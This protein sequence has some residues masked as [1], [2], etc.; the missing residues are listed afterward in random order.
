MIEGAVKD[1][2]SIT[3]DWTPIRD[4]I[5]G[6]GFREVKNVLTRN[7]VTTEVFREEWNAGPREI[8]HIIHVTI[9]PGA[10]SAWHCHEIQ[11]DRIFVVHGQMKAALY[12]GRE[13]SATH[14][15]VNVFSLGL[16][17]PGLLVVPPGV[18]HG[19]QNASSEPVGFINF[20]DRAYVYED[21]DEWRLPADTPKIPY[22]F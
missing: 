17:R 8:K 20:F 9:Q 4:M 13:G 10:I 19:L 18:W 6:V 11:T 16:L 3:P 15:R 5:E 14:G 2:Q 7:G 22:K 12:D 21:P 1:K